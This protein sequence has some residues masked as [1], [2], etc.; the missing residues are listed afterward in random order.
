MSETR[1]HLDSKK[2]AW[3]APIWRNFRA[4]FRPYR[5]AGDAQRHVLWQSAQ[6]L[7][8]NRA[9]APWIPAITDYCGGCIKILLVS[10]RKAGLIHTLRLPKQELIIVHRNVLI[11]RQTAYTIKKEALPSLPKVSRVSHKKGYC[12]AIRKL[13][14][15]NG[16]GRT[17]T[18]LSRCSLSN[19][20]EV[21]S[22]P[23]S[24]QP[25]W[26]SSLKKWIEQ[27]AT[28]RCPT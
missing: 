10:E 12:I 18:L 15:I 5:P 6:W 14:Q 23:T 20:R 4:G 16:R 25:H 8:I 2:H 27:I 9:L 1:L 24:S 3:R 13:Q 11:E 21:A 7:I 17:A 28:F 26:Q 22:A 19:L